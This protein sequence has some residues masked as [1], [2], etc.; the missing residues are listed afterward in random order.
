MKEIQLTQGKVALVD[1]IDYDVLRQ[2]NWYA[3][4]KPNTF[5][6]VRSVYK[7]DGKQKKERMHRV[8]LA[9]KIGREITPGMVP[10]H[11]DGNGLNNQ[12]YNLREAT[13]GQNLRNCRKH[14]ANPSS[15]HVGV[16]RFKRD[17]KW[18]A[19]IQVGGKMVH[20]GYYETELEAMLAREAYINLHP[21]LLAKS[22]FNQKVDKVL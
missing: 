15:Q 10:D 8:V 14:S 16:S 9:R 11:E 19:Y 6:A 7:P 1:D 21:E 18:Q 5:Y 2:Y 17:G 13:G 20:L 22:N 12:C 3:M 4:R